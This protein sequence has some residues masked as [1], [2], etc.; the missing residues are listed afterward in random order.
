MINFSSND[1]LGLATHPRVAAAAAQAIRDWG[2][3]AGASR[4]IV[5]NM[6]PHEQL[7]AALA[8]WHGGP[9]ARLFNSGYHANV[10][11]L[12]ALLGPQDVI[13][14]DALNHAS[15]VDG[16]RLSRA[17]VE[18]YP[19][20]DY[21]A[22]RHR[23]RTARNF[24]RRMLVSDAVFSMDGDVADITQLYEITKENDVW[25]MVDEAHAAGV[26]GPAGRGL[27]AAA[28]V[29]PAVHMGTL[30]KAVGVFGG[31]IVAETGIA[32]WLMNKARSFVFTT[33][34]PPMVVAA[35]EAAVSILAGREGDQLRGQL[36]GLIAASREGVRD[37]G[38]LAP[39]AGTTQIFPLVIG[40]SRA[41]MG[42]A[43]ALLQL[44]IYAQG[45]RPPTVPRGTSRLRFALSAAHSL[46]DV[47][48]A[49]EALKTCRDAGLLRG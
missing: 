6:T 1:Y 10:G 45:V 2:I 35:A 44:G 40:E 31:Y 12:S 8:A 42:A 37:L 27:C 14:S 32:D 18:I 9:A 25:L 49:L 39:G 16:C 33:A 5:G 7:E 30:S 47:G 23:M 38:L 11:T 19:H 48:R 24:R 21:D 36:A 29:T 22:A 28:A 3:G 46:E 13:F 43:E 20:L 17:T 4:L 41:T 34:L 26:I 15:I